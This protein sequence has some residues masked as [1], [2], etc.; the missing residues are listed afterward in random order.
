MLVAV[1][2]AIGILLDAAGFQR[3]GLKCEIRGILVG[4]IR[5]KHPECLPGIRAD[6]RRDPAAGPDRKEG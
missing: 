2:F 4:F 3:L 1:Y 6:L 5:E